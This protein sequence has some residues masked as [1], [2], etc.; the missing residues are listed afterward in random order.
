[1]E[2]VDAEA[3]TCGAA[4]SLKVMFLG[5]SFVFFFFRAGGV[6]I[7]LSAGFEQI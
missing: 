2:I 1:M 7:S 6:Y 3:A 4:F 5:D